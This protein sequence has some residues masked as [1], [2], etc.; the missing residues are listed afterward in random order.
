MSGGGRVGGARLVCAVYPKCFRSSVAGAVYKG[1]LI[2]EVAAIQD[3]HAPNS[4]EGK[5]EK[6]PRIGRVLDG[7]A[8]GGKGSKGSN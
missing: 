7:P 1:A 2:P 5:R 8:S 4:R 6:L 3:E